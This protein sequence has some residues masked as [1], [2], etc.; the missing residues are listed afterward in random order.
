MVRPERVVGLIVGLS[1]TADLALRQNLESAT[2]PKLLDQLNGQ[3]PRRV[4]IQEP[5]YES[6]DIRVERSVC[7][8][9]HLESQGDARLI[10]GI[11][12]TSS[13]VVAAHENERLIIPTQQVHLW[14]ERP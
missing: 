10:I 14:V 9:C 8:D 5:V 1:A 11:Q 7:L 12:A 13:E 4:V 3:S 2:K 6:H